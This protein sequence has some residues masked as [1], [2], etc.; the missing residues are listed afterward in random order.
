MAR[1][2]E[3][4]CDRIQLRH[5]VVFVLIGHLDQARAYTIVADCQITRCQMLL[6]CCLHS[7]IQ[8]IL[9]LRI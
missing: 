3:M 8:M 5:E 9:M 4:I 1:F 2:H 6:K 7:L